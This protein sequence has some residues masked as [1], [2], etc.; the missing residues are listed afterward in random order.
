MDPLH[1]GTGA[2]CMAVSANNAVRWPIDGTF[3]FTNATWSLSARSI[4]LNNAFTNYVF[5]AGDKVMILSPS[6]SPAGWQPG[7]YEI[8][9]HTAGNN[10]IVL[11]APM[12]S[13]SGTPP[14]AFPP[15]NATTTGY[16]FANSVSGN[17]GAVTA[18]AAESILATARETIIEGILLTAADTAAGSTI[19]IYAHDGTTVIHPYAIGQASAALA[20]P[21]PIPLGVFG[22]RVK[23]GISAKTSTSSTTFELFFRAIW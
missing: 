15:N 19:T 18:T 4:T 7:V 20:Y 5:K 21:V 16:V 22:R 10:P 3:P 23:G 17:R 12:A 11:K 8:E 13:W 1:D 2:F 14:P 9:S 6:A